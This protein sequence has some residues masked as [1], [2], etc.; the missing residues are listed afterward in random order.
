[1]CFHLY[2]G[3]YIQSPQRQQRRPTAA[4]VAC[5]NPPII[6]RAT[7]WNQP[8]HQ[9]L[10]GMKPQA[11]EINWVSHSDASLCR[12]R[13]AGRICSICSLI[14]QTPF[15][16]AFL[17]WDQ[18]IRL[19]C[20]FQ[21]SIPV[22]DSSQWTTE[23]CQLVFLQGFF[24]VLGKYRWRDSMDWKLLLH[25]GEVVLHLLPTGTSYSTNN[26]PKKHSVRHCQYIVVQCWHVYMLFP[27][28][29]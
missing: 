12:E 10:T 15:L 22:I 18:R 29:K 20:L 16:D 7:Y 28:M 26:P 11:T 8:L 21:W 13:Q 9:A 24:T 4:A 23:E 1:M 14:N 19:D 2:W 3:V 25:S 17:V 5:M 6:T 27:V